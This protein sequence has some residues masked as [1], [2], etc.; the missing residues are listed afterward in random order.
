MRRFRRFCS[1]MYKILKI[2]A[3]LDTLRFYA[4]KT[5]HVLGNGATDH[6]GF[7]H[8]VAEEEPVECDYNKEIVEIEDNLVVDRVESNE[9]I[10]D[11][12]DDIPAEDNEEI[13]SEEEAGDYHS[14][15]V[16]F[17]N[18]TIEEGNAPRGTSDKKRYTA[19]RRGQVMTPGRVIRRKIV[20]G[21]VVSVPFSCFSL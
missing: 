18:S 17:A 6:D 14:P 4:E 7:L 19:L 12:Y 15:V 11:D 1:Q 9:S 16:K 5:T 3:I 20:E 8:G 21:L 2:R 13:D 10:S